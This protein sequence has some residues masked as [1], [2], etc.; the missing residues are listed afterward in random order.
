MTMVAR[1]TKQLIC[2][3]ILGDDEWKT[4]FVLAYKKPPPNNPPTLYEMTR[5]IGKLGGFLGRKSDGEPGA[6][7][8][9]NGMNKVRQALTITHN[10]KE[11]C[12]ENL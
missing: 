9:W 6:K 4:A 5:T 8:I 10:L 2:T 3:A 1:N 11:Y 7:A 12:Y